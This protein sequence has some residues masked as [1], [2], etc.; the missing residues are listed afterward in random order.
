METTNFKNSNF[1]EDNNMSRNVLKSN[2]SEVNNMNDVVIVKNKELKKVMTYDVE[3]NGT[4][5]NICVIATKHPE[6]KHISFEVMV[7]E[8]TGIR[9]CSIEETYTST[10][11][12]NYTNIN[13]EEC[14]D[15]IIDTYATEIIDYFEEQTDCM[16]SFERVKKDL[17]F[18]SKECAEEG[19]NLM[20]YSHF[21]HQKNHITNVQEREE[22]CDFVMSLEGVADPIDYCEE[23]INEREDG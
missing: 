1:K 6:C 15:S 10:E 2:L 18:W 8:P 17:R 22:I 16:Y 21:I 14:A 12:L 13:I 5:Y 11:E 23:Y 9:A 20:Y 7:S 19:F 4:N 3:K